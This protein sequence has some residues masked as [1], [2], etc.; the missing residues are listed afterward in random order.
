MST[1]RKIPKKTAAVLTLLKECARQ[2]RTITYGEVA[3]KTGLA[4]Q[5]INVPLKYI[6]DE[7]CRPYGRPWISALVVNKEHQRPS[8]GFA[9]EGKSVDLDDDQWW[10]E[11]TERVYA[12][13]WTNVELEGPDMFTHLRKPPWV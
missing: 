13:D 8:P 3:A 11:E 6:E 5:G 1:R 9:P 2:R 12:H 10:Q 7:V 4:T